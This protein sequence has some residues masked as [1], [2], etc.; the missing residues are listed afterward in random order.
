MSILPAE[1]QGALTQLL[2][3]LSSP[4]NSLRAQAEEQLNNDWTTNRPDVLLMG[5]VE[6]MQ[7]AADS[8]VRLPQY[9]LA[10]Y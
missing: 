10:L 1:A 6:Q 5:L 9:Y 2:Q 8:S 3:A 4:E 7:A